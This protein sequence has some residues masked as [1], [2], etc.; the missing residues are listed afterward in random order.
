[1]AGRYFVKYGTIANFKTGTGANVRAFDR[2]GE[3]VL[4]R[5]TPPVAVPVFTGSRGESG[6]GTMAKAARSEHAEL[7][8]KTDAELRDAIRQ[9]TEALRNRITERLEEY[10]VMAR[11]VGLEVSIGKTGGGEAGRRGRR[12]AEAGE[13]RRAEVAAKYANPD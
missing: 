4:R 12:S 7:A 10:R 11:E 9:N 1:M 2:T 13:D 8:D 5:L 3:R 6:S